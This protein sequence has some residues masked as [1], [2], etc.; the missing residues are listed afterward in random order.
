MKNE[1]TVYQ[2]TLTFLLKDAVCI[3]KS[4][5]QMIPLSFPLHEG[6]IPTEN[7][8]YQQFSHYDRCPTSH[9]RLKIPVGETGIRVEGGRKDT[10]LVP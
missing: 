4:T 2:R 10:D 5:M 1:Q 8:V 6:L 3:R 9:L 7:S